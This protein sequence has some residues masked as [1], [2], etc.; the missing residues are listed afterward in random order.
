MELTLNPLI[1]RLLS[2]S[3]TAILMIRQDR[4]DELADLLEQRSELIN[5][6]SMILEKTGMDPQNKENIIKL[7]DLDQQLVNQAE[8]KIEQYRSALRQTSNAR[9]IQSYLPEEQ[10]LGNLFSRQD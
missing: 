9:K 5:K 2:V 8:A 10:S 6:M 3:E 7:I 1:N 4:L